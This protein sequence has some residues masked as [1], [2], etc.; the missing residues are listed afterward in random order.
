MPNP[1]KA[2]IAPIYPVTVHPRPAV[3]ATPPNH[4]PSAFAK[5]NAA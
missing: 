1:I 3:I 5:L 4:G 2:V